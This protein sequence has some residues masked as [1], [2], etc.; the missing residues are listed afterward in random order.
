MCVFCVAVP[1]VAATGM[2]LD[3]NYRKK[4]AP[5]PLSIRKRPFLLITLVAIF[6]MISLSVYFHS[7]Q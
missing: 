3:Q 1:T 6:V 7:H 4:H 5:A 2:A